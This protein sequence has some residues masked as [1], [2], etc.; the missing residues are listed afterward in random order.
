MKQFQKQSF[1]SKEKQ[2]HIILPYML[3]GLTYLKN[4]HWHLS[5]G[6]KAGWEADVDGWGLT[7]G[8]SLLHELGCLLFLLLLSALL[9][10]HLLTHELLA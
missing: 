5:S 8:H 6:R 4:F 7:D 9:L 10:L 3:G 1:K 2:A